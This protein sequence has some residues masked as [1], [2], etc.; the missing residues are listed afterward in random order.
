MSISTS[1]RTSICPSRSITSSTRYAVVH[2]SGRASTS[3]TAA[4]S[5]ATSRPAI[6]CSSA[7][8]RAAAIAWSRA[9]S[10]APASA[11]TPAL[12][13]IGAATAC[14]EIVE[15]PI[16]SAR[17]API[18]NSQLRRSLR[19]V[20]SVPVR[21]LDRNKTADR[22]QFRARGWLLD[23]PESRSGTAA[24][25]SPASRCRALVFGFRLGYIPRHVA[26]SVS[27]TSTL[28]HHSSRGSTAARAS[29][30]DGRPRRRGATGPIGCCAREG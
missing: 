13:S 26:W 12:A 6:A 21:A 7:A 24:V 16:A 27:W 30:E 22:P 10:A 11:G 2:A 4:S 8:L 28:Q 20:P 3:L 29:P 18:R 1:I 14:D 9:R 5:R 25:I 19:I 17:Q 15:I 23:S